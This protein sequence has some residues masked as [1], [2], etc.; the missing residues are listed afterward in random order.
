MVG[1]TI[2]AIIVG[3][4]TVIYVSSIRSSAETIAT[5]RLNQEV[6]S[7]ML[8]MSNDIRRA[9]Y[10]ADNTGTTYQNNPFGQ[11][12]AT[13]IAVMDNMTDDADQGPTG[14]GSCLTYAYDATY[15]AG[16]TAGT[17]ETA[18]LFGFRLNG[19]VVQMR[20]VGVVD[21]TACVGGTCDSCNNG[22]WE[23]L[24]DPDAVEVT[25]LNFDLS[26]SLCLNAA[27][28]DGVDDDGANGVDDAAEFNCYTT[29]PTGG[30]GDVTA[31]TTEV[32]ITVTARLA[33]DPTTETTAAQTVR[34]RNDLM[35]IR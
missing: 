1:M 33:D 16:N 12:G 4:S 9:G 30:S 23:N 15:L 6:S 27:E 2:G 17:L 35:R 22:T 3:G 14:Q 21:G 10:W 13:A 28:P 34:V 19:T 18:D 26:N 32:V 24:T 31:E 29:V 8:V 7:L 11:D 25:A 5:S 20:R